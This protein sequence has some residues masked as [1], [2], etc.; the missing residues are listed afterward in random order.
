VTG[1]GRGLGRAFALALSNPGYAIALIARSERELDETARQVEQ[2]GGRALVVP[3]DITFSATV[4][5]AFAQVEHELG[6]VDL[7]VNN[8]GLLGTLGPFVESY[9]EDW[10]RTFD[11]NLR[12]Q[13]LCAHRVLPSMIARKRGRIVNMASGAGARMRPY[14]SAYVTSKTALIRFSECLAAEVKPHGISVF[15]MGPG[16]V[17]TAMTEHSLH[18]HEGKTWLPWFRRIFDEG[19]DLPPERPAALLLALA[20]GEWDGLSGLYLDPSD[21]LGRIAEHI[22]NVRSNE[23]YS[24]S[25][26]KLARKA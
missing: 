8:A 10:W 14:Y 13:A 6:E 11:T 21:D 1:A 24:L 22:S 18:S 19:E 4:A 3:A 7:L 2:G 17:R 9:V 15:A 25:I 12:A 26:Q 5:D 16:T 20:S 23:A